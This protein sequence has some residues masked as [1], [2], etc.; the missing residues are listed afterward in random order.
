[1]L[2]SLL[3]SFLLSIDFGARPSEFKSRLYHI[4][5][6]RPTPSY[7]PSLSLSSEMGMMV[8]SSWGG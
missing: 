4:L 1:M 2:G 7:L 8:E 3:H 5:A 6:V